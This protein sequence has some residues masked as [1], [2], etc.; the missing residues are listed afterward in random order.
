MKVRSSC[1]ELALPPAA[2]LVPSIS[3]TLGT[4]FLHLDSTIRMALDDAAGM[5]PHG[6][7]EQTTTGYATQGPAAVPVARA[8][9]PA[10][11]GRA[12]NS[13]ATGGAVVKQRQRKAVPPPKKI[14]WLIQKA[15]LPAEE[16]ERQKELFGG[17]RGRSATPAAAQTSNA[18]QTDMAGAA[19]GGGAA[20]ETGAHPPQPAKRSH[21]KRPV[22]ELAVPL[23]L[24]WERV[25]KRLQRAVGT[26]TGSEF[27]IRKYLPKTIREAALKN[28]GGHSRKVEFRETPKVSAWN[29]FW[30]NKFCWPQREIFTKN[31]ETGTIEYTCTPRESGT[32]A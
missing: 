29:E 14:T 19:R 9:L 23:P 24:G 22:A 13:R 15:G 16:R 1:L 28:T 30:Q 12:A 21:H 8:A 20:A 31:P 3:S 26:R 32:R 5:E 17:K 11:R 10:G 7:T 25:D 18:A 27:G 2:S 4:G 6:T